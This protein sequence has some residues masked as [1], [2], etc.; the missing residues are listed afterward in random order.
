M[1]ALVHTLPGKER[2][3][4]EATRPLFSRLVSTAR[5]V[6]GDE[7]MSW[8]AVQEALISLWRERQ[9]PSDPR[10]WLVAAVVHRSLHLARCRARRTKHENRARI[11][12]LEVAAQENPTRELEYEE[13]RCALDDAACAHL[14][15]TQRAVLVL[16]VFE[17][18]DYQAIAARLDIPL[19]TVRSRL[20]RSRKALR[21]ALTRVLPDHD[22]FEAPCRIGRL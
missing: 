1:S 2:E 11:E 6:L 19:G 16:S 21:D 10:A 17:E 8:D 12:H 13:L 9:F 22:H 14:P 3:F 15:G 7:D 20:N 4:A 5:R 18:L